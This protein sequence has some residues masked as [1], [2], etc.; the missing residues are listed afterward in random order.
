MNDIK[1]NEVD[2]VRVSES[3]RRDANTHKID[4][5]A[6]FAERDRLIQEK[7][8]IT[9]QLAVMS[10]SRRGL[11]ISNAYRGKEK[12]GKSLAID[13]GNRAGVAFD[14]ERHRF[15]IRQRELDMRLAEIRGVCRQP[16]GNGEWKQELIDEVRAVRKQLDRM[17]KEINGHCENCCNIPMHPHVAARESGKGEGR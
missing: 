14:E 12:Q 9:N 1:G 3:T 15:V 17:E 2:E 4:L 16:N 10:G 6:V 5:D 13:A 7:E 8:T 11:V